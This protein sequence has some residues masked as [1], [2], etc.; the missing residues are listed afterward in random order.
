MS[1]FDC[2]KFNTSP[3][4]LLPSPSQITIWLL[5]FTVFQLFRSQTFQ[6]LWTFLFFHISHVIYQHILAV[7]SLKCF[8]NP[9]TFHS[10]TSKDPG[11]SHLYLN[12]Y[13][14]WDLRVCLLQFILHTAA[15]P[16]RFFLFSEFPKALPCRK[17]CMIWWPPHLWL[18]FSSF[19]S[20]IPQLLFQVLKWLFL[21]VK[22]T[23]F[24]TPVCLS[25]ISFMSLPKW[26]L[27]RDSPSPHY[28]K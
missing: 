19:A 25:L 2:L 18:H 22:Y 14:N 23:P 8:Q 24:N 12:C 16:G 27:V 10:S 26:Y 15:S 11:L 5:A 17:P 6:S 9:I 28:L 3:T 21:S 7:L 13:N 4:N 1:P 20:L